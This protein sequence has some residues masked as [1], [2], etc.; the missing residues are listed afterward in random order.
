MKILIIGGTVFLGRHI[1]ESAL[2]H[3]H[4][5]TLFNRGK[6]GH[7]LFPEVEKLHGDRA[8]DLHLLKGRR[9]DAVID[10]CGYVPTTVAAST[11][12]LAYSVDHYTFISTMSVYKEVLEDMDETAPLSTIGEE[13]LREAETIEP[14]ERVV[15]VSYGKSY[16][17]LKALCERA[18]EDAMPGR[19]LTVRSAIIVGPHD[20]SDRFT[21]WVHRVA[22]GGEVLAPGHPERHIEFTDVRDLSEWIVRMVE[23]GQTGIYNTK[24]PD[25]PLTMG[26]F[27][28]ECKTVTGSDAR[29]TWVSEEFLLQ[30]GVVPWSEMPLW[31]PEEYRNFDTVNCEK[32][33]AAGLTYRPLSE[34]IRDTLAWDRT[35]RADV[36]WIAGLDAEREKQLL[37]DWHA[38]ANAR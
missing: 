38:Q 23:R 26:R 17:P 1:V 15:A 2:S 21:Y 35:R 27:L 6:H 24:G 33:L 4:T 16:G 30:A 13:Q 7:D 10:T 25:Y 19:V 32:A 31:I 37:S 11:R 34:T 3:G 28:D 14:R 5:L 20:Y 12:A 29:F 18:A 36:E 8:S 22:R 9:W